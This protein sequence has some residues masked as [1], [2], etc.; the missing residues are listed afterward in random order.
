M[1]SFKTTQCYIFEVEC[2]IQGPGNQ[3]GYSRSILKIKRLGQVLW[4]YAW[5]PSTLEVEKGGLGVQGPPG[6][7]S[8]FKPAWATQDLVS[9]TQHTKINSLIKC[10]I[11]IS[12][13]VPGYGAMESIPH[14]KTAHTCDA[15]M[16]RRGNHRTS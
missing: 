9:K 7:C 3:P 15:L 2:C 14:H 16:N 1:F 13:Q 11:H 12:Q 5:N 10:L 6:L 8:K 4:T